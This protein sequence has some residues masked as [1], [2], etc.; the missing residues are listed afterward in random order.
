MNQL[1]NILQSQGQIEEDG[2]KLTEAMKMYMASLKMREEIFGDDSVEVA[3]TQNNVAGI[4]MDIG[5]YDDA[6]E[7]YRMSL[8]TMEGKFGEDAENAE[9][10]IGLSC[11]LTNVSTVLF[12]REKY[13]ECVPMFRRSLELL[14]TL[15]G[16]EHPELVIT[17]VNLAN[18][19]HKI[20]NKDPEAARLGKQALAITEKSLGP[21]N[22]LTQEY[23]QHWGDE[24]DEDTED[25]E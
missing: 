6:E 21:D 25:D 15:H 18:A 1:G 19:L 13:S 14:K 24:Q 8:A 11:C 10:V 16:E 2:D 23:R 3:Q 5:K 12:K 7:L 17:L 20:N 4:M 22:P 9:H